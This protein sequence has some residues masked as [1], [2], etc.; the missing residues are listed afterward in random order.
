VFAVVQRPSQLQV[1]NESLP[2]SIVVSS[3]ITLAVAGFAAKWMFGQIV[4][5]WHE[6]IK[7]LKINLQKLDQDIATLS[8]RDEELRAELVK[9]K[10]DIA[11]EYVSREDWIRSAVGLEN[12]IERL[13]LRMDD[14]FDRIL[15]KLGK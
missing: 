2:I 13:G 5:Y 14:K 10:C 15:E 6:Q 7:D 1:T 12:K 8:N 4:N 3:T 11:Q 9:F